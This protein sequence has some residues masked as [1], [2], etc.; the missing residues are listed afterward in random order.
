MNRS[1]FRPAPAIIVFA[2]AAAACGGSPE[3]DAKALEVPFV[4]QYDPAGKGPLYDG[5]MNCGPALLAGIAKA[6]GMTTGYTD[7]EVVVELAEVAGTD[8]DGTTGHGMIAALEWMGM[9]TDASPGADLYWIDDELTAGHVVIANGDYYSLP[10]REDPVKVA[11]HYIA[12]TGVYDD[13]ST[14]EVVDPAERNCTAL[15]DWQ[16]A[17]FIENATEGG[18]TI[19]AW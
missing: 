17:T 11:G 6:Q 1:A 18:F 2:L 16:L 3:Y 5:S 15:A 7:A 13:W 14:Y 4:D 19:S 9:Q 10:G 12:V 8:E